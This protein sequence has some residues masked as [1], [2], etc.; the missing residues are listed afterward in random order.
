MSRTLRRQRRAIRRLIRHRPTRLQVALIVAVTLGLAG[1]V[2]ALVLLLSPH[3]AAPADAGELGPPLKRVPFPT[4][5][6]VPGVPAT[7]ELVIPAGKIDIPVIEGD[8]VHVPLHL[9]MHYPGTALPGQGSNALYYA[10]AQAGMFL[11]LYQVHPGD[12]IRAVRAD[13]T[14]LRYR[15]RAVHTVHWDDASVLAPTPF[16]EITLLTCTSYNPRDPRLVVTATV[17]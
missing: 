11:G 10:H 12:E 1:A 5:T 15:V 16:E 2:T 3:S 9:A 4:A 6:V 7:V 17:A 8:G 14:Q 13:G